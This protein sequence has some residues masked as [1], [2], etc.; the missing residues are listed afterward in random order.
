MVNKFNKLINLSLYVLCNI[1]SFDVFD[2]G[3]IPKR[4]S[5]IKDH[6]NRDIKKIQIIKLVQPFQH[7]LKITFLLSEKI[8]YF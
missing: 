1:D 7:P 4:K 6:Y 2:T 3:V 5:T 8:E